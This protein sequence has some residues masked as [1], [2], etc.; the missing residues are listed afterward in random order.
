MEKFKFPDETTSDKDQEV[1]FE[2]EG[3]EVNDEVT[4]ADIEIVDDTPKA[5]RGRKPLDKEVEEPTEDE[6]NEYSG[7]VQRRIKE[8]THA[9]HDER[10]KAE[11]LA[12]DKLELERAAKL[13]A[14]ENRR[15]QEYVNVGQTAYIDKSKSLAEYNVN[16]AK[17][18]LKQALDIGDTEEAV[19]AQEALY[20]AHHEMQEVN[21]FKP[22]ALQKT[23]EPVYTTPSAPQSQQPEPKLDSRVVNWAE[24]NPWFEKPGKEDMTDYAYVVHKKLMRDHGEAYAT[25]DEYYSKIDR[26]MRK[27]FPDEFDVTD[28]DLDTPPTASRTKP[29]VAPARRTTAPRKFVLTK[30]QQEVAKQ[31]NIPLAL[32]AQKLA[33]MEKQNG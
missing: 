25:T 10:R 17:L 21:R 18:R 27:A 30:R 13:L 16:A 8:L 24:Q 2:L 20:N 5:D 6:L 1:E 33:E 3:D 22:T 29:V 32:Y 12:R 11:A 7:K 19:A 28:D 15:L 31:L 4:D 26:A 23:Q 9:R 14:D